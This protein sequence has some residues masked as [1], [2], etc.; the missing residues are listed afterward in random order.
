MAYKGV[1]I[2]GRGHGHDAGIPDDISYKTSSIGTVTPSGAVSPSFHKSFMEMQKQLQQK[3]CKSDDDNLEYIRV[4]QS[5]LSGALGDPSTPCS[6]STA[7]SDDELPNDSIIDP[8]VWDTESHAN[9]QV[10]HR[11][12]NRQTS[13]VN[14]LNSPGIRVFRRGHGRRCSSGISYENTD[15]TA[16]YVD[17][18]VY[19]TE[20]LWHQEGNKLHH[21]ETY[22][23]DRDTPNNRG[24]INNTNVILLDDDRND[25]RLAVS[26]LK[27]RTGIKGQQRL[28]RLHR[29]GTHLQLEY[30]EAV[31]DLEL[32]FVATEHIADKHAMRQG[33]IPPRPIHHPWHNT[34]EA[35]LPCTDSSGE[36]SKN[37]RM[38]WITAG[39]ICAVVA[40]T[41]YFR[42]RAA[43]MA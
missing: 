36:S 26:L 29:V 39:A 34:S 15:T 30:S 43:L 13:P 22:H 28:I 37:Y 19:D 14:R 27:L 12:D 33:N 4:L 7:S 6:R 9:L 8:R 42:N 21:L 2:S 24:S 38:L 11:G 25:A 32:S 1:S 5:C 31:E 3:L 23:G 35:F 41:L 16:S 40:S 20:E 17:D 18:R 10:S